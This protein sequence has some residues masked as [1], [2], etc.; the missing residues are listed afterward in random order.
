[1][2]SH[3][4]IDDHLAALARA[5]PADT[6][7][8]L[9]DGLAETWQHH[10]AD[11]LTPTAAAQAAIAE[12]GTPEQITHAFVAQAPGR[13]TALLLLATGPMVGAAWA[14]SL[15]TAHA[16]AWPVPFAAKAAFGLALLAVV[17]TLLT[18]ATSRRSYRRTRLG[19]AA[20]LGVVVLD[21]AAVAAALLAA[22]TLAWPMAVAIP[23]SLARS[24][25]ALRSV[26]RA[27]AR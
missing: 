18:A 3:R 14:G 21:T 7:E 19:T 11:G 16:W 23:A 1:M 8:E 12:F 25:L 6:V 9:A 17:A 20:G 26:S 5:L 24:G 27:L 13:R 22:P 4:L 15:I 10:V 2:A